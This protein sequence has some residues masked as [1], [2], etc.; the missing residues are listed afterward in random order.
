MTNSTETESTSISVVDLLPLFVVY[1]AWGGTYLAIR[2]GVRE[3]SGFLPFSLG[4]ARYLTSGVL[5]L[6]WSALR[7]RN[8]RP[9]K[10]DWITM[11]LAGVLMLNGG[12]GLVMI[13]EKSA[14]SS[15]AALLVGAVP[16]WTVLV[17]S[18]IDRKKPSLELIGAILIGF[19]GVGLL[20]APSL[21]SGVSA[22]ILP[23]F[24]LLGAGFSWALG[25][26]RQSRK[27]VTLDPMVSSAY[28]MITGGVGF[29]LLSLMNK[30]PFPQPTTEAWLALAYLVLF[31]SVFAFTAYVV[32][33]KNLP[34]NIVMTYTYVNPVI[35]VILGWLF[36]R[37]PITVWTLGGMAFILLGVAGVFRQRYGKKEP[38]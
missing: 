31:G 24:A 28:Q 11:V 35:A 30:E 34:I 1:I 22:E 8:I 4:A 36:L 13:A 26:I 32:S 17:E 18:V 5:L 16:I 6:G 12:N 2:Y 19:T 3:G 9:R 14:D 15:L 23:V 7:K 21:I 37:E 38:V 25:S 27:P 33:L 29:I 20:A 10:Q